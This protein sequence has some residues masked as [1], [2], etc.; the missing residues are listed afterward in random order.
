MAEEVDASELFNVGSTAA[1][2]DMSDEEL[3][4]FYQDLL[5]KSQQEGENEPKQAQ[6]WNTVKPT[7]GCCIKTKNIK[8]SEKVF[9]NV[10][11]SSN[12][13]TPEA[14][15]EQELVCMLE[16]LE[17]RD[18][19]VDYR[20]PMSLGEAHAEVDNRGNGCTAYDVI[21]SPGF[22]HTINNSKVFFG[23]FMS[24]V[25]EGLFNKYNVELER[26]WVLLKNKKFLGTVEEQN[27]RKQTLI[28]E[29]PNKAPMTTETSTKK[30]KFKIMREPEEGHPEFLI[31]EVFLPRIN[32]A[33]AVL[34]DV[35]E[36][37][38]VVCTRP[39]EYLLDIFLPFNLVQ[40]DC[41]SQFDVTTK[42]LTVTMPVQK[43][44]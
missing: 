7:P 20:V 34:V 39:K 29:I 19:I 12:V 26:N 37:R 32:K 23:F 42:H 10:C 33:S 4:K 31:A 9:I 43:L 27:L 1:G 18:E 44:T 16:K 2:S 3:Q 36:D 5:L 13:P 24:V 30:P 14:I 11:T 6:P 22:L 21:I 8:T 35:G 15:T 41:G 40:E 25:F 28:Q 17:D 38:L